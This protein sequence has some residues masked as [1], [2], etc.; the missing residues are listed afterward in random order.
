MAQLTVAESMRKIR[1]ERGFK[2]CD[3]ARKSGIPS[4]S[5]AN[6]EHGRTLPTLMNLMS[7]ADFYGVSIDELIGRRC[8]P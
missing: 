5:I 1:E 6:Y 7:L 8:K 2:L 4:N 3:V